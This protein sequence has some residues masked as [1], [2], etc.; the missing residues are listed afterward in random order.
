[1]IKSF[2]HEHR[3]EE[4]HHSQRHE[5]SI[6]AIVWDYLAHQSDYND[7]HQREAYRKTMHKH[8]QHAARTAAALNIKALTHRHQ[9]IKSFLFKIVEFIRLD[10]IYNAIS[11]SFQKKRHCYRDCFV[12]VVDRNNGKSKHTPPNFLRLNGSTRKQ[13]ICTVSERRPAIW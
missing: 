3:N 10:T 7:A 6:V 11:L 1:M 2:M 9:V 8:W 4:V 12:E 5:V 13:Y